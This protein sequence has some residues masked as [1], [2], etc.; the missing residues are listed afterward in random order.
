MSSSQGARKEQNSEQ[1]WLAEKASP[2]DSTGFGTILQDQEGRRRATGARSCIAKGEPL[3]TRNLRTACGFRHGW[4]EDYIEAPRQAVERRYPAHMSSK[5]RRSK[6]VTRRNFM[7]GVSAVAATAPSLLSSGSA[8]LPE[9]G[10]PGLSSTILGPA[11]V[12]LQLLV[13]GKKR[14]ALVEARTTLLDLLRDHLHITGAKEVCDLGSCGSCTV[15][16][17]GRTINAC[18]TLALQC[19]GARVRTVEGLSEGEQLHPLQAAF[20]EQDA[21]QCGYCTPGILMSAQALLVKNPDASRDEI[22]KALAGNLCRCGTYPRVFTACEQ[23][24]KKMKKR[25]LK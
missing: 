25:G 19:E 10:T 7:A 9:T 18:M 13:N 20:V 16:L 1:L 2:W 23:A 6:G 12:P 4:Q 24:G 21:L 15:E 5:H 3:S 14:K 11:P 8:V 22:R 17:E